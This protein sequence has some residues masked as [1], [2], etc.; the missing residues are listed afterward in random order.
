MLHSLILKNFQKP[1]LLSKETHFAY[2]VGLFTFCSL[3]GPDLVVGLAGQDS[4]LPS[5]P[6]AN[7]LPASWAKLLS[8]LLAYS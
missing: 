8:V 7:V 5:L 4:F 1:R 2:L 6:S 3:A